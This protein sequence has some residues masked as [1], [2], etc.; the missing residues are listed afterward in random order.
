MAALAMLLALALAGPVNNA[1]AHESAKAAPKAAKKVAKQAPPAAD[2]APP[3]TCPLQDVNKL[4]HRPLEELDAEAKTVFAQGCY[5]EAVALYQH[6]LDAR[7]RSLPADDPAIVA[8]LYHLAR[9]HFETGAYAESLRLL[10]RRLQMQRRILPPG[11]P[12]LAADLNA[13]AAVHQGMSQPSEALPLLQEALAIKRAVQHADVRTAVILTN[14]GVLHTDA[15]QF[16]RAVEYQQEALALYKAGLPP[17]HPSIALCLNNLA[18]AYAA[19]GR[20]AAAMQ[21][22]HEA[23]AIWRRTLAPSHP[24]LAFSLS[25]LGS[26]Y[27]YMGRYREALDYARQ[28]VVIR[29]KAL[30]PHHALI[31]ASLYNLAEVYAGM[32]QAR[33]AVEHHRAALRI[34][35]QAVQPDH[36]MIGKILNAIG[37][38]HR[39]RGDHAAALQAYRQALTLRRNL[40][41]PDRPAVAES[42]SGLGETYQS[43]GRPA[44]ALE[45]ASEGFAMVA[46]QDEYR[47]EV[48]VLGAALGRLHRS[49]GAPDLAILHLKQAVNGCQQMRRHASELDQMM[50]QAQDR[51]L[52][53]IYVDLIRLLGEQ[54]RLAEAEQ[55][56]S[57]LKEAAYHA[58]F[59]RALRRDPRSALVSL[60]PEEEALRQQLEQMQRQIAALQERIRGTPDAGARQGLQNDLQALRTRVAGRTYAF[61]RAT[62][63]HAA[64]DVARQLQSDAAFR[65]RFGTLL[66][67]RSADGERA[68]VLSIVPLEKQTWLV[69]VTPSGLFKTTVPVGEKDLNAAIRSFTA[70]I[71]DAGAGRKPYRPHPASQALYDH[72]IHPLDKALAQ[73]RIATLVLNLPPY[74]A[75]RYLP[76]AALHDRRDG[77]YLAERHA[78]VVRAGPDRAAA[79]AALA[80]AAGASALPA[81]TAAAAGVSENG[82][83]YPP[84]PNVGAELCAV[85]REGTATADCNERGVFAGRRFLNRRF[86]KPV[87]FELLNASDYSVIHLATHFRLDAS[88]ASRSSLLLGDDQELSLLQLAAD[89][90]L[91][92][93]RHALITLSACQ[94]GIAAPADGVERNGLELESLATLLLEHSAGSVLAT[95]WKIDDLAAMQAMED[96]YQARGEQR[97]MSMAAALRSTQLRLL[98]TAATAHPY[99]WAPFVLMGEWQ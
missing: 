75:M 31:G 82:L 84:L 42:L 46:G 98:R 53:P 89:L 58:F 96:F 57:M 34:Y 10:H 85:V 9:A 8:D 1:A 83:S 65:Q 99:Y 92:A 3:L 16:D 94:T 32:G 64:G 52:A 68:A 88:N 41:L 6:T 86:S 37:A 22:S 2:A 20:Y 90:S 95:L 24:D 25:N 51:L 5:R 80:T 4:A 38:A 43:L 69:L 12:D 19:Q 30:P 35:R 77:R 44:E 87:L 50:R 29:R 14:L 60:T 72:L 74:G 48:C 39:R 27:L 91:D 17:D 66:A 55:V 15:G 11:H 93:R 28:A 13:I 54:G 7:T 40:A 33:R 56:E 97:R 47:L 21:H 61:T 36:P 59:E 70:A 45:H 81:W 76:F 18:M 49:Q 67:R 71:G 23:L 26:V 79:S 78:L 73:E 63:R 62:L